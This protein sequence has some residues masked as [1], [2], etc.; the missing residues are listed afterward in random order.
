MEKAACGSK[1]SVFT[2][3][4]AEQREKFISYPV[5]SSGITKSGNLWEKEM[6]PSLSDFGLKTCKL[7]TFKSSVI[8]SELKVHSLFSLQTNRR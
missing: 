2:L 7:V 8:D 1:S 3:T 4:T 6:I 5:V